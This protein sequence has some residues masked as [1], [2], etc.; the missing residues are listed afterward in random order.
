MFITSVRVR[1]KI[2]PYKDD[3]WR[4]ATGPIKEA[5]M[6]YV[7]IET[8]S[9]ITGRG[10][11]SAGAGFISGESED[12]IVSVIEGSFKN[13]LVGRDPFDIE[14]IMN[15]LDRAVYMNFRAKAGIDLAL[16]DLIGRA[17]G[18]P[19]FKII[20]GR[21]TAAVPIMRLIGLKEP[22]AMA[23]D[24]LMLVNQGYKALKV[25]VGTSQV[26]DV[27]RVRAIREA[28][29]EDVALTVDMNGAYSPKEAIQLIRALEKFNVCLVE[30][31]V[32]RDNIRG[33][34]DVSRNVSIPV[35]ADECVMSLEDAARIVHAGAADVMS[36]KL[37]KV[38]GIRKAKKIASLCE[39]F[40]IGCVVGA[41]PGSQLI[42]AANAHFF[43]S[44]PNVWWAAE[45]GEFVRMKDDPV[46]GA[47]INN[48]CLEVPSSAGL[49]LEINF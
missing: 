44:T 21:S 31:P 12:S 13:L 8:D 39:A 18:V 28:V 40:G 20:G 46:S 36:V 6:I 7:D 5:R 3:S 10:C 41:T 25:K 48:G 9:G 17:L 15:L 23:E 22:E 35:E 43:V 34:R 26:L 16:H 42:D 37:L 2:L 38:G 19:V 1:K 45:V 14:D 33:L 11:T 24:A 27:E 32:A 47:V 4:I 29:G 49:G 30:Q